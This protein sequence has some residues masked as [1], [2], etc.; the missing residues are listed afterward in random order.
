[1]IQGKDHQRPKQ[2]QTREKEEWLH[3]HVGKMEGELSVSDLA[4]RLQ[5]QGL[6]CALRQLIIQPTSVFTAMTRFTKMNKLQVHD[7]GM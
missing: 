3:T 4:L 5:R 7:E 6:P 1:M 2:L